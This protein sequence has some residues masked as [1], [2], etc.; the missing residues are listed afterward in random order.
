MQ[1]IFSKNIK[2]QERK[3]TKPKIVFKL[4]VNTKKACKI[5]SLSII[6]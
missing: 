5:A 4:L 6:N 1:I 3:C 2:L